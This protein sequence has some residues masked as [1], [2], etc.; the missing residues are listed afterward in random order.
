LWTFREL[1]VDDV[2]SVTNEVRKTG[3]SG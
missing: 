2:D 1:D 3:C